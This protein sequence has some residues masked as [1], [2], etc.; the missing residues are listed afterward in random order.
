MAKTPGESSVSEARL[1]KLEEKVAYQDKLIAD[2]NDV[3]VSLHRL[4]E[5]LSARFRTVESAL[6]SEV[7]PRDVPNEKPPHY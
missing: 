1:V 2:L 7:G 3:V 6:R 4:T 5:A